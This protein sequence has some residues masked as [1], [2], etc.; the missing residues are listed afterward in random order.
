MEL[1]DDADGVT[2]VAEMQID[3]KNTVQMGFFCLTWKTPLVCLSRALS[4]LEMLLNI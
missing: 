1:T 4:Y 3:R 2:L